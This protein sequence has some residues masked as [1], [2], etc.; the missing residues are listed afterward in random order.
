M[1]DILRTWV[2][3]VLVVAGVAKMY[4][5]HRVGVLIADGSSL[6]HRRA[7]AYVFILSMAETAMGIA[8]IVGVMPRSMAG[9]TTI[10]AAGF[11]I[12]TILRKRRPAGGCGCFGLFDTR[13]LSRRVLL[14]R[15]ACLL[16]AAL[17][18]FIWAEDVPGLNWELPTFLV[19]TALLVLTASGYLLIPKGEG[20]ENAR[21][22]GRDPAGTPSADW[23]GV[24]P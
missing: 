2:G 7:I 11:V 16:L 22:L 20:T 14:T 18:T 24:G 3:L 19:G 23:E 9:A 21:R 15:D 8:L 4:N 5:P 13:A 1:V 17:G 12:A 10:L 6:R